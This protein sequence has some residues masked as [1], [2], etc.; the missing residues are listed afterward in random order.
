MSETPKREILA[1]DATEGVGLLLELRLPWLLVGLI[2]AIGMSFMVSRYED[3]LSHHVALAFFL[4]AIVYM[5]SA[6]GTQTEMIYVRNMA[7]KRVRLH[8]YI[9]KESLLGVFL[10]LIL[11][12]LAGS[13]AN[14]WIG[15]PRVAW[16]VG[17]AMFVN[18]SIAP[19]IALLI[20]SS[21]KKEHTDPALGAGP[22][23][24]IIQDAL[25]IL[26][27]FFIATVIIFR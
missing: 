13:I 14:M 24:T 17:L 4:P 8:T 27:Y 18:I 9:V 12:A 26:I 3:A 7:R 19:L 16:S 11:G 1:D 6:V 22:F 2:G 15:D 21:L 10:G 5:S 25:S 20:T 23:V